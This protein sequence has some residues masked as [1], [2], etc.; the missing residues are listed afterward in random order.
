MTQQQSEAVPMGSDEALQ[1]LAML[2]GA[3][4]GTVEECAIW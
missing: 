2:T 1:L 3:L 4:A